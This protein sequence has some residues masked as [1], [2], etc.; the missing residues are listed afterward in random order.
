MQVVVVVVDCCFGLGFE[1]CMGLKRWSLPSMMDP[2]GSSP[3]SH[4]QSS[5]VAEPVAV[6]DRHSP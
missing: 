6:A 2:F 1:Y 5:F 4:R 3:A